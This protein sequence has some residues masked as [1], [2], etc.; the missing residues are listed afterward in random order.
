MIVY[1]LYVAKTPASERKLFCIVNRGGLAESIVNLLRKYY[2]I[3][4]SVVNEVF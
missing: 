4:Y 2:E 3:S 1:L